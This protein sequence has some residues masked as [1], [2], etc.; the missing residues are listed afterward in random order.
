MA[1]PTGVRADPGSTSRRPEKVLP[2]TNPVKLVPLE[3]LNDLVDQPSLVVPPTDWLHD[4]VMVDR[5]QD[6]RG[7]PDPVIWRSLWNRAQSSR[8]Q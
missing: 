6:L 8:H 5:R 2:D 1:D 4:R 3:L 7:Q